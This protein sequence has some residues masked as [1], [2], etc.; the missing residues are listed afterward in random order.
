MIKLLIV[1]PIIYTSE[2]KNIKKVNSIKDTMIYD[3]CLGFMKTG[4]DITLAAA[5]EYKPIK[6]EEDYPFNVV[7]FKSKLTKIFPPNTIPFCPG[8]KEYIRK[9]KFDLIIASEVFSLNSLMLSF[10]S[11][12]NLIVWHELAKHNKM[13]HKIPSKIWYNVIA[14]IFFRNT[15]IV[16]RSREAKDFISRFCNNVSDTVIDHGVNL[17]KFQYETE[18]ENY[19]AVSSQLIGRK[20]IDKTIS[21]FADYVKNID[22]SCKLYIMGEGEEKDNLISLTEK[23]NIRNNVIF[24]GKLSHDKLIEILKRAMAMLVYTEKDNNM[25]SIVESIALAT[26]VITTSVPYNADY[27][28]RNSLGIVDDNWDSNTLEKIVKS[29]DYISNCLNYRSSLST[30]KKAEE[31]IK[32]SKTL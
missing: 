12:K 19:F 11:R 8:I 25:V 3:L 5:E 18:K 7:W 10:R 17:D 20:R 13:M 32:I 21:V 4:V 29:S 27:I 16:A 22:S 1:N 2:T 9:N 24:T 26:P 15:K 28:K 31:F 14:R 23:L 6:E 30:V